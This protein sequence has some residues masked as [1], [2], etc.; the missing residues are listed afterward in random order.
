LS[1]TRAVMATS[2]RTCFISYIKEKGYAVLDRAAHKADRGG[3][4]REGEFWIKASMEGEVPQERGSEKAHDGG[5]RRAKP[6]GHP[7]CWNYWTPARSRPFS[8]SRA[9]PSAGRVADNDIVLPDPNVSRV[10]ARLWC[11]DDAYS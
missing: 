10:H 4:L 2:L 6:A 3:T 11:R 8:P 5:R 9:S 1:H 7:R